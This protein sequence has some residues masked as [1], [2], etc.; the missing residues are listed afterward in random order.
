MIFRCR[1]HEPDMLIRTG[2]VAL[3]LGLYTQLFVHPPNELWQG[4]AD[5]LSG[6]LVGSS[7]ALNLCGLARRREQEN[8]NRSS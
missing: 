5:S 6:L 8:C 3:I 1:V 2:L 4:L 7:I